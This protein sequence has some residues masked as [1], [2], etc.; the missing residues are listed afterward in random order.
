MKPSIG[1]TNAQMR[2]NVRFLKHFGAPIDGESK[3]LQLKNKILTKHLCSR[4]VKL[5]IKNDI[6]P[7]SINGLLYKDTPHVYVDDLT[8]FVA[9][10]LDNYHKLGMLDHKYGI[11]PSNE[12]WLKLGGE[13]GGDSF[14]LCL[15]VI[16]IEKPNSRKTRL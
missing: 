9:N 1:L 7:D 8:K 4:Y 6:S 15:Q 16:N 13:H 10:L 2:K 5:A 3:V 14:K 11:I 12:I